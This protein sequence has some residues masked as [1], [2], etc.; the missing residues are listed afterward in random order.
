MSIIVS[1]ALV[2]NLPYII[3]SVPADIKLPNTCGT[4]L[5]TAGNLPTPNGVVPEVGAD[6]PTIVSLWLD[7]DLIL[8]SPFTND[9][10]APLFFC[11]LVVVPKLP[12]TNLNVSLIAACILGNTELEPDANVV[13]LESTV[14]DIVDSVSF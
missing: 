11:K 9:I 8:T 10:V 6:I 5:D 12:S 7:L 4:L 1:G 3:T 13:S 14:K 2:A